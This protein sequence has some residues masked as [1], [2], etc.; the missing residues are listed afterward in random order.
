MKKM[1]LIMLFGFFALGLAGC[2]SRVT[3]IAAEQAGGRVE[4]E[5]GDTLVIE[6]EGNPTT[7]YNWQVE[8]INPAVLEQVGEVQFKSD[9]AML[10]G[11]GGVVTLTFR[12]VEAGNSPL[13]LVYLRSWEEGVEPIDMFN[14]D[15][16]VR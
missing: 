7:G 10:V 13:A 4:L 3:R 9:N 2:S 11:S 12:A 8:E 1:W 16:V 5:V 6:L 15:V 14:L